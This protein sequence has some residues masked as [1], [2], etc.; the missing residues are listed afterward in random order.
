MTKQAVPPPP[1]DR[2]TPTAP[3]PPPRWRHWLWPA[4]IALTFLMWVLLPTLHAKSVPSHNLTYSQFL[5]DVGAHK[6]KSV[7]LQTNGQA[8][9]TLSNGHDYTTVIPTPDLLT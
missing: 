7:T 6:I 9:G 1:G 3:P 2:P 5:G 8:S 4:A